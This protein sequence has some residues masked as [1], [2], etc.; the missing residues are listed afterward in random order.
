MPQSKA[1]LKAAAAAAKAQVEAAAAAAVWV[2]RVAGSGDASGQAL[3]EAAAPQRTLRLENSVAA[4]KPPAADRKA[5]AHAQES[6]SAVF[7]VEEA[8][9]EKGL[10]YGRR[11][12]KVEKLTLRCQ[13]TNEM[14][15]WCVLIKGG[16]QHP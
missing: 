11:S 2:A 13:S 1:E 4:W 6:A 8:E 14:V 9:A 7:V 5:T 12:E 16:R 3:Q 10:F 15:D